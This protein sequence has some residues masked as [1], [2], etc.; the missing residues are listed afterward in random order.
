[1]SPDDMVDAALAGLEQGE[2]V[3]I[4]SLHEGGEWIRFEAARR[5]ISKQVGNSVPAARYG[6]R[7]HSLA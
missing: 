2:L 3:T 5:A 1:M 7:T 4:P 6:I